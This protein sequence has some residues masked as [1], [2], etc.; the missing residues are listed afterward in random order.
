MKGNSKR[1]SGNS[2]SLLGARI[3]DISAA[4]QASLIKFKIASARQA[5]QRMPAMKRGSPHRNG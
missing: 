1:T 5:T 4:L 3:K 2:L